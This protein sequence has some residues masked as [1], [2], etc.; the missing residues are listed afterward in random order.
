[1][2]E[3]FLTLLVSAV[4]LLAG[5]RRFRFSAIIYYV[6]NKIIKIVR[7]KETKESANIALPVRQF[8]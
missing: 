4:N 8:V 2:S 3:G 1:M 5:I 6:N 7:M